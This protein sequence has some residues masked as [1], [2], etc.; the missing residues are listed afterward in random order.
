MDEDPW[1]TLKALT[2]GQTGATSISFVSHSTAENKGQRTH[3]LFFTKI[4]FYFIFVFILVYTAI[5][6][7]IK[8]YIV[9]LALFCH[10]SKN[11]F[12]HILRFFSM[13][14]ICR[15]TR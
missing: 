11:I 15:Y 4:F 6:K 5:Y 9:K 12:G 1:F 14:H 13:A 3:L 7:S 10:F 8:F 2:A